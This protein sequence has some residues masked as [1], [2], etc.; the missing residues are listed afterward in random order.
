L[1]SK[2]KKPLLRGQESKKVR[3]WKIIPNEIGVGI[4]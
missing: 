2:L 3:S 1:I 4:F